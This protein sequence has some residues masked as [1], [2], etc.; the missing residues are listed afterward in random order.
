ML[1][2]HH[3]HTNTMPRTPTN[4]NEDV[5]Q[6]FLSEIA[7][8]LTDRAPAITSHHK[9]TSSYLT[10]LNGFILWWLLLLLLVLPVLIGAI[11]WTMKR[12]SGTD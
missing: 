9:H 4:N 8:A 1:K 5:I 7:Y 11:R 12:P 6:F 10:V 2:Y 3:E